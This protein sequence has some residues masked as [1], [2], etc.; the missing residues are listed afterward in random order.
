MTTLP[1]KYAGGKDTYNNLQ[2]LHLHCHDHKTTRDR[3]IYDKEHISEERYEAKVSRTVL[4]TS[5]IGDNLA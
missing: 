3:S 1:P 5:Q 4:Q 2:L